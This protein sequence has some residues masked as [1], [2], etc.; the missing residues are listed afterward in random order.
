MTL[1]HRSR[2]RVY[3]KTVKGRVTEFVAKLLCE[4]DDVETEVLRYDS[5]HGTPHVDFL[6]EDGEVIEKRWL[7][8]LSNDQALTTAVEDV[9]EKHRILS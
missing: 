8:Y 7:D 9:K 4:I 2:L 3:V 1:D 6:H 5:G